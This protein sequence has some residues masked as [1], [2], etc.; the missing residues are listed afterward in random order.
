MTA[1]NLVRAV[2]RNLLPVQEATID[3]QILLAGVDAVSVMFYDGSGW[4]DQW[5][6]E[7]T[8][9]LPTAIKFSLTLAAP[10]PQSALEP[11]ELVVPILVTTPTSQAQAQEEAVL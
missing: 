11:I 5:D 4:T 6:S 3:E 2:T 8:S 1:K 9:T 7:A 10:T